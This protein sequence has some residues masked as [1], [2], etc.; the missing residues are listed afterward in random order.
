MNDK[1]NSP[2]K[3]GTTSRLT[4]DHGAARN[5][6]ENVMPN[7]NR[8]VRVV[9]YPRLMR[10]VNDICERADRLCRMGERWEPREYSRGK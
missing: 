5:T 2:V 10:R 3:V 6:P 4:V 9:Y 8:P 1:N 7:N